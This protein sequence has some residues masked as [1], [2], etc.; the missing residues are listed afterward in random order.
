[1]ADFPP[2]WLLKRTNARVPVLVVRDRNR[3]YPLYQ[4]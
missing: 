3:G 1:L 2:K 4:S